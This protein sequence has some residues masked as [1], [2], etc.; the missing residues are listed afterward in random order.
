MTEET[1]KQF[2]TAHGLT[3][4]AEGFDNAVYT[5]ANKMHAFRF[6]KK[7]D[8]I[9]T[10]RQEAVVLPI[11]TFETCGAIVPAPIVKTAGDLVYGVYPFVSGQLY[12]EVSPNEQ[13]D[14]LGKTAAFLKNLRH[15]KNPAIQKLPV[16]NS[17]DRFKNV[18]D[19]FAQL[20]DILD[21]AQLAYGENLFTSFLAHQ[22]YQ[23]I[24]PVLVHGDISLDHVY[25]QNGQISVIDWSDFQLADPAYDFHHLLNEL[26][27]SAH[28]IF[29]NN[30]DIGED[31]SFW[32][33][34][35]AYCFMD[36]FEVLLDAIKHNDAQRVRDFV[37]YVATDMETEF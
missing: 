17:Y 12:T 2:T 27:K 34:A 6:P 14:L 28:S 36:T 21:P 24:E 5:D 16:I 8:R 15:L 18:H 35:Y 9:D 25:Y 23:A 3:F 13:T 33:R 22:E 4:V 31:Q 20:T 10:L 19:G 32:D 11:L 37:S 1:I 7:P 29:F 30:Y 26:P